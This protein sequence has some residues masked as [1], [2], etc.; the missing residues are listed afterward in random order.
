MWNGHSFSPEV[1]S[2]S[3]QCLGQCGSWS[4]KHLKRF[5]LIKSRW[6]DK[7]LGNLDSAL[8]HYRCQQFNTH[9]L[10]TLWVACEGECL[11]RGRFIWQAAIECG[12][13]NDIWV[14]VQDKEKINSSLQLVCLQFYLCQD[15]V[16]FM[17]FYKTF[18][19]LISNV[20]NI[21]A[22]TYRHTQDCCPIIV[23]TLRRFPLFLYEVNDTVS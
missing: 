2:C 13:Q 19:P 5:D 18:I 7:L 14:H 23:R 22:H 16:G 1:E 4:L 20:K 10:R 3:G 11:L 8:L 17:W 12:W 9:R 15:C 21:A 6:W